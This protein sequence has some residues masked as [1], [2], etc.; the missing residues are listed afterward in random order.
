MACFLI[1]RFVVD[2]TLI[3]QFGHSKILRTVFIFGQDFPDGFPFVGIQIF[4]DV[5]RH[6]NDVNILEMS[7]DWVL[8]LD[9]QIYR[10]VYLTV[11]EPIEAYFDW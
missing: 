11:G 1:K 9:Y 7:H 5:P 2:A 10:L 4:N 8:E 3:R 6:Q